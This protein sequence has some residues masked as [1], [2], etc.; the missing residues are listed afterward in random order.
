MTARDSRKDRVEEAVPV[1][2]VELEELEGA[3]LEA[4][5]AEEAGELVEDESEDSGITLV[6][7]SDLRRRLIRRAERSGVAI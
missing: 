4:A 3:D 2:D 7:S 6:L 1:E 5:D